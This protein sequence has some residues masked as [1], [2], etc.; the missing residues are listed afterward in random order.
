[1]AMTA[2]E[3]LPRAMLIDMDATVLSEIAWNTIA[4]EFAAELASLPRSR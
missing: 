4:I 1:M 3:P 2:M